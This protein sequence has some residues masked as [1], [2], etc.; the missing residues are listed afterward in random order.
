MSEESNTE[1][2]KSKKN[3]HHLTWQAEADTPPLLRAAEV[4]HALLSVVA[5]AALAAAVGEGAAALDEA[6]DMDEGAQAP[7]PVLLRVF[8]LLVQ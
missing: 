1:P 7:A 6:S 3:Y 8:Y 4:W 5:A 2:S